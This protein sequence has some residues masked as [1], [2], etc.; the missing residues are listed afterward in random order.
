MIRNSSLVS[1]RPG[2]HI[3]YARRSCYYSCRR[4]A[5]S[6]LDQPLVTMHLTSVDE[7]LLAGEAGEAARF[8]MQVLVAFARAVGAASLLDISRAHIDGCLYHGEVNLDFV[9]RMVAGGGR[10]RVPTTL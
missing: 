6:T 9:E 4:L 3:S 2:I 10:V 1:R 7:A 5:S 8:A